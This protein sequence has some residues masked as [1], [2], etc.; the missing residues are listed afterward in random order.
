M[1][2]LYLQDILRGMS[3]HHWDLVWGYCK[4]QN[5]GSNLRYENCEVLRS[6][7][8]NN[9]LFW[10]TYNPLTKDSAFK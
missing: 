9:P 8:G 10:L 5:G 2:E 4:I 6:Y 1:D 7:V 3:N